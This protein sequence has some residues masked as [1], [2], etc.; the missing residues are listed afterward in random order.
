MHDIKRKSQKVRYEGLKPKLL[1]FKP[2]VFRMLTAIAKNKNMNLKSYLETLAELQAQDEVK[3][4][5]LE[6]KNKTFEDNNNL[7]LSIENTIS[8]NIRHLLK[9]NTDSEDIE[10]I[11]KSIKNIIIQYQSK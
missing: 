11:K 5:L 9:E 6:N 7:D 8:E 3:K 2:N 1:H 4:A 10:N